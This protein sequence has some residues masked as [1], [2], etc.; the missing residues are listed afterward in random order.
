MV[1]VLGLA[2]VPVPDFGIGTGKIWIIVATL[3]ISLAGAM[4]IWVVYSLKMYNR[5]IVVFE[6]ISG[7]GF[8]PVGKDRARLVSLG[9]GGEEILFLKKSKKYRTAYGRKMGKNTYWFAVGQDGYWYNCVLGDIDAKLGMLDIEPIDRD[10]RYMHVA[11]RRNIE[12]RYRKKKMERIVAIT[13]G[14]I[15]LTVLIIVIGSWF[16]LDKIAEI[17]A[18]TADSVKVAV[19]VQEGT[20]QIISS[21]AN[22][23]G[24]S[25]IK[26]AAET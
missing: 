26:P 17:N 24:G 22:I 21:L 4:I 13:V 19:E 7:Q 10:M 11:I 14:G 8:Q 18:G 15:V 9:D 23:C 20:R 5:K 16:I 12:G 6:N 3:V 25:G 2:D 1:D